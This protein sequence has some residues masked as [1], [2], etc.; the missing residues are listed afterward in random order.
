MKVVHDGQTVTFNHK[1]FHNHALPHPVRADIESKKRLATLVKTASEV[2]PK[3]LMMGSMTRESVRNI[4]PLFSNLDRVAYERAKILKDTS[5]GETFSAMT[6]FEEQRGMIIIRSSSISNHDGHISIQT[7]FM[8]QKA[9]SIKT[10]MQSD[11]VHGFIL[12]DHFHDVNVTFTT[13]LCPVIQRTIPLV[14]TIMFGKTK[15]H[16]QAHF[17]VLLKS[18]PFRTWQDFVEH[19]PGMT[20]DFS[21][22]ERAGFESALRAFYSVSEQEELHLEKHYRFCEVHYKRS[23]TRVRRNGAVVPHSKEMEFYRTAL[24]LLDPQLT[25][26]T[27]AALISQIRRDYPKAEEWIKWHLNSDRGKHIFPGLTSVDVSHLSKDTNAQESLGGDFQKLSAKRKLSITETFQHSF[28]YVDMIE[29]DHGAEERGMS[30]R[31]KRSKKKSRAS[32]I[33][34]NDGRAPDTTKTLLRR[35]GAGRP[36]G[37]RNKVPKLGSDVDWR[38]FGIPWSISYKD[39]RA[40]NTCP[41]DTPLMSW[42]LLNRFSEATLPAEVQETN[43][44]LVLS[45]IMADI[46]N[47]R[48]DRAR[49]L[50][51]TRVQGLSENGEHSLWASLEEAFLK[52]VPGLVRLTATVSS[53]CSSPLCPESSLNEKVDLR[54]LVVHHPRQIDQQDLEDSLVPGDSPCTVRVDNTLVLEYGE[55]SFRFQAST[56]VETGETSTW[57]A[58]RGYRTRERMQFSTLPYLLVLNC[59]ENWNGFQDSPI[60]N[61]ARVLH[62]DDNEY[63]LAAIM[64]GGKGHFCCT[65]MIKGGSLFYD[66]MKSRKLQWLKSTGNDLD[67][68]NGFQMSQVWYLQKSTRDVLPDKG[69]LTTLRSISKPTTS[70]SR[71]L[72]TAGEND[73][74]GHSS[75]DNLDLRATDHPFTAEPVVVTEGTR[76]RKT[77]HPIGLSLGEVG[78][79]GRVP[80]CAG[81]GK[82]ISRGS[83]RLLLTKVV[84]EAKFWTTSASFHLNEDCIRVMGEEDQSKARN[85]ISP[86]VLLPNQPIGDPS[87]RGRQQRFKRR[88]ILKELSS[89]LGPAWTHKPSPRAGYS[90]RTGR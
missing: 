20:C 43:A 39:F 84:N 72:A 54:E 52:Y 28:L 27:F 13:A 34:Y 6:A 69:P 62:I 82:S 7:D 78:P 79:K 47:E 76:R 1:G 51:C 87:S 61:P 49:W 24:Q 57:N 19:F 77:R 33:F 71:P 56:D 53:R 55:G 21:D 67:M 40:T 9:A 86:P 64:Y 85:L 46:S 4:H 80:T 48:Y 89:S 70:P 5:I 65:T 66:G 75:S 41:L 37:S 36:K 23:L 44:G 16:Y 15:I 90:P 11:S 22:A 60:S 12:D 25:S 42:Y 29:K 58:C 8:K 45:D 3:Q 50:W 81:C 30:T 59:L 32:K 83:K 63:Y 18:L 10:C 88:D 14:I 73:S 38:T 17:Q 31:Y 68:P 74:D 26:D 2:L 35:T